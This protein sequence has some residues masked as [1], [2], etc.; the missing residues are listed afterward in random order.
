[1]FAVLG[2]YC[3]L[4]VFSNIQVFLGIYLFLNHIFSFCVYLL[5]KNGGAGLIIQNTQGTLTG[6]H[7]VLVKDCV[8][9]IDTW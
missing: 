2:C 7:L 3:N 1:M 4:I 6:K 5:I 9:M 8:K